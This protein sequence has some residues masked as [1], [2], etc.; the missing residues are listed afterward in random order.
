M[1]RT[2]LLGRWAAM[3]ASVHTTLA[4]LA[5]EESCQS[6][7]LVGTDWT[8]YSRMW[9]ISISSV[10]SGWQHVHRRGWLFRAWLALWGCFLSSHIYAHSINMCAISFDVLS[11]W[12]WSEEVSSKI[13]ILAWDGRWMPDLRHSLKPTFS[14]SLVLRLGLS[15]T[16]SKDTLPFLFSSWSVHVYPLGTPL[17]ERVCKVRFRHFWIPDSNNHLKKP[18]RTKQKGHR[19]L[20]AFISNRDHKEQAIAV[21]LGKTFMYKSKKPTTYIL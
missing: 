10:S 4:V 6:S 2:P 13:W 14:E 3:P 8:R 17:G 16:Y 21:I 15:P 5:R 11:S 18:N 19:N 9:Q 20:L 12:S 7:W 1:K